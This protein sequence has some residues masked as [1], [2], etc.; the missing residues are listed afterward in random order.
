[1]RN[2]WMIGIVAVLVLLLG[3]AVAAFYLM[4]TTPAPEAPEVTFPDADPNEIDGEPVGTV[5]VPTREGELVE[6]RDF[7]KSATTVEDS[8]NPGVYYLAGSP[9]YC[10]E[11]GMCPEAAEVAGVNIIYNV[12]YGAFTVALLEEPLSEARVRA[13]RFLLTTLA[14]TEPELCTLNYYVGTDDDVNESYAGMNLGF[15]FCPGATVLP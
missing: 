8:Q 12:N 15:S 1:M 6:I 3:V 14:L 7:T 9:D 2:L 4:Q 10:Y 13:E 11:E 5:E